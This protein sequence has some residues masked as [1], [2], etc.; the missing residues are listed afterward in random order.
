MQFINTLLSGLS[1]GIVYGLIA[2]AV[3]FVWRSSRAVNFAQAGQAMVS[4]F[5]ALSV[6]QATGSWLLGLLVATVSGIVIGGIAYGLVQRALRREHESGALIASLG[7]LAVLQAAASMIW[8]G[9]IRSFPAPVSTDGI[10]IGDT[11]FLLSR[12]D[13]LVIV[14]ASLL[15]VALTLFMTRTRLGLAM[16]AAAFNPDV[17]RISGVRVSRMLMLGWAVAGGIGAVGGVLIAPLSFLSPNSFDIVIVFAFTAA[18]VGG[19]DSPIGA[20]VGGISTGLLIALVTM[21]SEA[22][23]APIAALVVLVLTLLVQPAGLFGARTVRRV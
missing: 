4:A 7:L 9:D 15:S 6:S 11:V 19:L 13:L 22:A 21:Y 16:R 20:M 10:K 1:S 2:L 17:A 8:G 12:Y 14:I 23:D 3:V 5:V 18:V